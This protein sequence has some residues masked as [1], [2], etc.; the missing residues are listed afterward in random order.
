MDCLFTLPFTANCRH[1]S[2]SLHAS[3]CEDMCTACVGGGDKEGRS[4]PRRVKLRR[5][6]YEHMFS[7]LTLKADIDGLSL[8]RSTA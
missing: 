1:P 4:C 6:Q 2:S 5:T 7:D 3:F 8:V